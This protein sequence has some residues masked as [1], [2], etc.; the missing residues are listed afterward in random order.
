VPQSE[1]LSQLLVVQLPTTAPEQLYCAPRVL[2][3]E[4]LQQV[5]VGPVQVPAAWPLH[6]RVPPQSL[7]AVQVF[8]GQ[9]PSVAPTHVAQ[10]P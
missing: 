10:L 1:L 5:F 3:S 2:Q 4:V 9:V 7:V 8:A 6:V